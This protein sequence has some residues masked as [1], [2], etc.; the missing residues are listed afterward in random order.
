MDVQD[1]NAASRAL[2]KLMVP[3]K[4]LWKENNHEDIMKQ[5]KEF[6]ELE[7]DS[8]N[9]I[10][11]LLTNISLT[12]PWTII[13]AKEINKRI[14][15]GDYDKVFNMDPSVLQEVVAKTERLSPNKKL[16]PD[17]GHELGWI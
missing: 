6:E 1:R 7:K 3:D 10:Y 15:E 5:A 9:K 11:K 17:C 12:H 8:L 2:S 14:D 16:C 13:R 4:G